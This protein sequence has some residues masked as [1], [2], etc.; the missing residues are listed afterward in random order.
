MRALLTAT[1][2]ALIAGPAVA[3][4]TF[5]VHPVPGSGD[6]TSVLDALVSPLVADGDTVLV[7]AGTYVGTHVVAKAILLA[8]VDGPGFT[9]LDAGG[10]GTTLKIEAG[11]TVQGF[12]ITGA[13]GFV[14]F[15]GVHV[16]SADRATVRGCRIVDNH[17]IGDVGI[18]VGGIGV[19][20]FAS[21]LLADNV[22]EGNTSL[23]VGGV[24]TGPFAEVD[25]VGNRIFG[26]GG[27]GTTT[28][29]VLFGASGRLVNNQIT[30]NAG[31]GIGGL[32]LS[33]G[34]G[35]A[36][37]GAVT[38][39]V[40]CT[41]A[42]NHGAFPGGGVGGVLLDAG[43][44]VTIVDT[45]VADNIGSPGVDLYTLADFWTKGTLA[46]SSS[47]VKVQA[48]DI[49]PGFDMVP[50]FLPAGFVAPLPAFFAPT[51]AGDYHL[52]LG[53]ANVDAGDAG[54]FPLDVAA[55]DLDGVLRVLGSDI[56][57]GAYELGT[58]CDAPL[59][60]GLGKIASSGERPYL[61]ALGEPAV[62]GSGLAFELRDAT[63]L[64]A[65]VLIHGAAPGFEPFLG[66]TLWIAPDAAFRP[67]VTDR[68]GTARFAPPLVP[69]LAGTTRTFQ[70]LF[71]DA[72]HLD[73]TG[74]GLSNAVSVTYCP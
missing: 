8:S 24:L 48:P 22:V 65:C 10:G 47:H 1:L 42:G 57:V 49:P 13:G 63:L 19:D 74:V 23:S 72:A 7:H 27:S 45:I 39:V 5:T 18:P 31:S 33:G 56:D 71:R 17:P 60:Y 68:H 70:V 30:G 2:A 25:L 15:G 61:I 66:G 52:A 20:A 64:S 11:A 53:S 43:G 26:N 73:G 9:V 67:S 46:L 51:I 55:G 16:T 58:S 40:S 29:G 50:A 4:G 41:I 36:P 59:Y 32:Y 14:S 21:A 62:S 12:E 34:L 6:F 54:A 35:P 28:G 69:A 37:E 3:A 38:Q 44:A